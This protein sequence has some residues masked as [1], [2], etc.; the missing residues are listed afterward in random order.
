[1]QRSQP[2][3]PFLSALVSSHFSCKPSLI[4]S[5]GSHS[6]VLPQ[7]ETVPSLISFFQK[8][9]ALLPWTLPP[10]ASLPVLTQRH[11]AMP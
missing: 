8:K 7:F 1:M 10:A 11:S 4:P 9:T 5:P 6:S 3:Q 2:T